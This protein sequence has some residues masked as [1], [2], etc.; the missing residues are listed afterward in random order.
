MSAPSPQL[1]RAH[2]PLHFPQ[3]CRGCSLPPPQVSHFVL[4][5]HSSPALISLIHRF[6]VACP[7]C[8]ASVPTSRPPLSVETTLD[9]EWRTAPTSVASYR[10]PLVLP[11]PH[12]IAAEIRLH[13]ECLECDSPTPSRAWT[14]SSPSPHQPSTVS[15]LW[16][17]TFQPKNRRKCSG[18]PL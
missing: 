14:V 17:L 4:V 9:M 13:M 5:T 7:W 1:C 16:R 10:M 2:A 8:C 12:N 6:Y 18:K 3:L 11:V 15:H